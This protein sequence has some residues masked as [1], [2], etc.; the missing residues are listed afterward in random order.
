MSSD[1]EDKYFLS[2]SCSCG[3]FRGVR[4]KSPEFARTVLD[5]WYEQHVYNWPE[6]EHKRGEYRGDLVG[7]EIFPPMSIAGGQDGSSTES[8]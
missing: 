6:R 1:D 8:Q 3:A 5:V 7:M 4:R 2:L